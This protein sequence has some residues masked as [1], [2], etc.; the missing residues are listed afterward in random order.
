MSRTL[1]CFQ[2]DAATYPSR[3]RNWVYGLDRGPPSPLPHINGS[4][5]S[6]VMRREGHVA[7]Q[8]AR[9]AR[10]LLVIAAGLG[11]PVWF[12]SNGRAQPCND[13]CSPGANQYYWSDIESGCGDF[14]SGTRYHTVCGGTCYN[15][16]GQAC[17]PGSSTPPGCSAGYYEIQSC[18]S[19]MPC[20]CSYFYSQ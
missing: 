1:S 2:P 6:S 20:G 7:S 18:I 14:P 10:A 12:A 15:A 4:G 11:G 3:S 19:I 8:L 5:Y 9:A 17:S 16:Q 13:Y